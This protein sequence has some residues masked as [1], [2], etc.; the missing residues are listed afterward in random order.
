MVRKVLAI[1]SAL[2][3]L[4]SCIELDQNLFHQQVHLHV[5]SFVPKI[6]FRKKTLQKQG[7]LQN[8][9][10]KLRN[11]D[12]VDQNFMSENY[13]WNKERSESEIIEYC[14]AALFPHENLCAA[15]KRIHIITTKLPLVVI[16]GFL[17]PDMCDEIIQ[18]AKLSG[19]MK[20]STLG[21][22]QK[23]S[24]LRTS[25]TTWLNGS[26]CT[27]PFRILLNKVSRLSG[28]PSEHCENLQVVR[29]KGNGEEFKMHTDHLEA[30]NGMDCRGR[31]A[32]CLLYLNSAKDETKGIAGDFNGGATHFPEYNAD[33]IPTKGTAAFWF[34]TVE[35]PSFVDYSE[36]MFLN[37][38]LRSRHSGNPVIGNEKWVSNL[39]IHPVPLRPRLQ[40]D[41]SL[42]LQMRKQAL[43]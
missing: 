42:S 9:H 2:F 13:F 43:C 41:T 36:E 8:S 16:H 25:S 37:V 33:I 32:T 11:S 34:N 17:A 40:G 38:D 35:R 23:V 26:Q 3:L 12:L 21:E 39:W 27:I 5:T 22:N 1:A 4:F 15:S 19:D 30:F 14:A 7:R 10:L 29:Y 28:I 24:T 20:R 18:A 6:C 31:L